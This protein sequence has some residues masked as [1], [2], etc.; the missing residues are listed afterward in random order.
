MKASRVFRYEEVA[1]YSYGRGA[2][3]RARS[4]VRD[5]E[6]LGPSLEEDDNDI[7]TKN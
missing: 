2:G 4:F 1:M 5:K 7:E 6:Q 3:A